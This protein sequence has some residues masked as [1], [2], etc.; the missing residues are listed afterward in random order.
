V[1]MV[2][3]CREAWCPN[4]QPCPDHPIRPYGGSEPMPPGWAAVSG[5][6]LAR[7]PRCR[8]CGRPAA[9]ADHIIP[10]AEGG[11]DH[12]ANLQ[13]L[14]AHCHAVK[15]GRAG[16]LAGLGQGSADQRWPSL[17]MRF[18]L[19]HRSAVVLANR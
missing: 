16:G 3:P 8:E 14:C 17:E 2:L 4:Y 9:Q 1:P 19:T 10:R 18:L 11:T 12:P 7:E 13:S 15:S 5:A 6:Q